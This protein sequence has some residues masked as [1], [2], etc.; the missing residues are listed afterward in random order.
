M[1][2][3]L[4]AVCSPGSVTL[5]A[6]DL[7]RKIIPTGTTY[8][9]V[10]LAVATGITG[11]ASGTDATSFAT[12]TLT[13]TSNVAITVTYTVARNRVHARDHRSR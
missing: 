3:D 4:A 6:A 9:L 7:H 12:G 8:R 1:N 5:G 2:Q 10:P 13:N 11:L